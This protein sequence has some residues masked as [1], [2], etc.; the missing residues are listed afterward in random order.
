MGFRA[1]TTVTELKNQLR[2]LFFT[3]FA[4][5]DLVW[6][7]GAVFGPLVGGWLMSNVGME[8]VFFLGAGAA[9][10]GVLAFVG[11]LSYDHGREGLAKW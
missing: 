8:W 7:P 4:V 9:F 5:R 1:V 2:A 6:R 3:R 10:S 11:I